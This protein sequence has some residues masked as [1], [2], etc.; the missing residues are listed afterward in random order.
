MKL[1]EVCER[2]N[3]EGSHAKR[4]SQEHRLQTKVSGLAVP[5]WGPGK[6]HTSSVNLGDG[7]EH[8]YDKTEI[9]IRKKLNE[10]LPVVEAH[11][12]VDPRTVVIH[13][14]DATV[15]N[16]TVV[17]PVRLPDI[18]H[19]AVPSSLG[20]ITHV[21]APVWRHYARIGHDTLVKGR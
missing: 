20:L 15:A 13:V 10:E 21:E 18:A 11:A 4:K 5:V 14:Q 7:E 9:H 2:A 8:H 12:V 3:Q 19:F 1:Y 16:T 17:C 6:F